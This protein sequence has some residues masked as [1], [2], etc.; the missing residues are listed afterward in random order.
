[1]TDDIQHE[2]AHSTDREERRRLRILEYDPGDGPIHP[3]VVAAVGSL[4]DVPPD[5]LDPMFDSLD[6]EAL[7]SLCRAD[8]DARLRV[9]FVYHG[10]SVAIRCD[11]PTV[12]V[13][14]SAP[15]TTDPGSRQTT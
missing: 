10:C 5:E 7:D 3:V 13:S 8:P 15:D 1:M 9:G 2:A 6:P 4:L 14:A 11:G 12:H